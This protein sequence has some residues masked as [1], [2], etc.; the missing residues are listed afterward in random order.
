MIIDEESSLRQFVSLILQ[1]QGVDTIEFTE[2]ATFRD[3]KLTRPPTIVFLSV[4]LEVQDAMATIEALSKSGFKGAV[5]LMSNRGAAVLDTCRQAGEHF[6]LNMLPALKKPFETSAIQKI[7]TDL[8]LGHAPPGARPSYRAQSGVAERLGRVLV[9]AEGRHAAQAA[10]RRRGFCPGLSSA[11]WRAEPG[12]LHAGRRRRQCAEA[13]RT[14]AGERAQV[15][16]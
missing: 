4:S 15:G 2:G 9:P 5:Q 12:E 3:A 1:G 14:G 13:C 6:K 8:K 10:G 16:A 7:I 11:A